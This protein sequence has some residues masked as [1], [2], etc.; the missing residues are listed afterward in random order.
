MTDEDSGELCPGKF[1]WECKDTNCCNSYHIR[2]LMLFFS[3]GVL[4][5]ALA[6][7]GVWMAF[8]LRPSRYQPRKEP[9]KD[10][11]ALSEVEIKSFE[12]TRYL[13]RMSELNPNAK[14]EYV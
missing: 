9:V 3:I 1:A 6:V 2:V 11:R 12:E 4:F 8:D 13:R 14:R 10:K 5:V 7:F